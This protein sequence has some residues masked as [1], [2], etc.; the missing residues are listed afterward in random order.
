MSKAKERAL[1][2]LGA[3]ASIEYGIPAT[4]KFTDIIETAVMSDPWV[5]SQQ[6]DVAYKTIKR[7]LKRYLYNPGI[8]HFEQIY[9]CAHELIYLQRP[10]AGAVDEFRPILVPFLKDTSKTTSAALRALVGKLTEVIYD[11]VATRS[12]APQRSVDPFGAFLT[13]L[14]ATGI[15]RLYTTNYDDFALQAGPTLYTGYDRKG[16]TETVFDVHGFWDHWC[17]PSLF[18]LHGSVHMSYSHRPATGPFADLVW[19]DDPLEARKSANFTGSSLR[20]MDGSEVLRTPIVTGLDK[21]SRLQQRPLPY[22]YAALTRDVMEADVIYVVG[23]GLGDLHLNTLL[24]EARSR[25]QPAPL[26]F[27]DW[28][29]GGFDPHADPDRKS[30]EMF[31]ALRIHIGGGGVPPPTKVGDWLVSSDKTAA[32]WGAGFHRFLQETSQHDAVRKTLKPRGP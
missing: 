28:W 14:E 32:I 4:I 26:L 7:R 5:Q 6:G 18:F 22:F 31:H 10:N 12:A 1:V 16:A 23:A 20:R 30:I 9:H 25:A 15:P 3:G 11:E 29:D 19:F 2:I 17:D 27:V 13:G 24:A 21:L 8:V